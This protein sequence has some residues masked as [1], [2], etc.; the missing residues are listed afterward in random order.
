MKIIKKIVGVFL[1]IVGILFLLL[2]FVGEPVGVIYVIS[3]LLIISGVLVLRLKRPDIS[4]NDSAVS[5]DSVSVETSVECAPD[6]EPVTESIISDVPNNQSVDVE[7]FDFKV[8]GIS[9]KEKDIIDSLMIENDQYKMSKRQIDDE[10]LV[11]DRIYKYFYAS[12]N[13]ELVP[14]PDNKYDS[15]AI[16]V[17]VDGVHVGYVPSDLTSKV[18]ALMDRIIEMLCDFYGGPYKMAVEDVDSDEIDALKIE[19]GKTN[20][21]AILILTYRKND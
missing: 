14:E 18:S 12:K 17:V 5:V 13:V 8:A 3:A 7:S 9:F 2:N 19:K 11:G 10:G 1:V 4:K 16:M 15:N 20:I 21:G 6:S